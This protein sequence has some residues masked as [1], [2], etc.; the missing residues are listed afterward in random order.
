VTS[1]GKVALSDA[2]PGESMTVSASH[3]VNSGQISIDGIGG[4]AALLS[5]PITGAGAILLG[6]EVINYV[7]GQPVTTTA[8][9]ELTGA[10][11]NN[12]AY[13]DGTGS[14]ILDNPAAVT[15]SFQHF[16]SGDAIVLSH[17][18]PS[19][20]TSY[21][22]ANGVL[23]VNE[24]G[25]AL[26]LHFSGTYITADFALSTDPATGGVAITGV[27]PATVHSA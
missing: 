9:V 19:S 7:R 2:F 6:P 16:T 3:I 23:T 25:T 12:L 11:S 20:V 17:V 5:G 21:S 10:D 22:Y 14:F 27:A 26:H 13:S 1:G 18:A 4:G 24:A 8:N 15:G